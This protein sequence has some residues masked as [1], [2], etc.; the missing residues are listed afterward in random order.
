[1]RFASATVY[2]VGLFRRKPRFD[3]EVQRIIS[4]VTAPG[5]TVTKIDENT[6]QLD[7]L[8]IG[9]A[10]LRAKWDSLDVAERQPWLS[11]ALPALVSPPSI[12]TRLET[13]QPLR[14]G[15]RPRSMLES[16]R[17]NN[18]EHELSAGGSRPLVPFQPFGGDLVTV[19][20]WDAP[21]TMSVVNHAQLE[22]WGA[23]FQDLLPVAI[24]N[25]EDADN[26]GWKATDKRVW[27]SLNQDDYAGARMLVPGF[28]DETGLAGELVVIHPN[29]NLLVV[30]AVDDA[31]GIRIACETA[32]EQLDA[33]SPISFQPL[34]GQGEDWRPLVVPP[35]HPAHKQWQ[36]LN[37]LS[38]E[39]NYKSLQEPLQRL[40]G[41]D[42][43][44]S[45][46][47]IAEAAGGN[48]VS[49]TTWAEGVPS[50]LPR[51]DM[52]GL[53]TERGEAIT[54]DWDSVQLLMGANMEPTDHYPELWRVMS[55]PTSDELAKLR[56]RSSR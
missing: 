15:I 23:R 2:V 19:L 29:R 3:D 14:P 37:C 18:L 21:A 40:V 27:T 16:A 35:S 55:F 5:T 52:I 56:S 8:V 43:F 1:M 42:V 31:D 11:E 26:A 50:L 45:G 10:N 30:T 47:Q 51:A 46:F 48:F 17:L 20:L 36:R 49:V 44:V 34:V 54:A 28:L 13:T 41:Q 53:V 7:G 24:D 9:L 32:L 22:E 33:P 4:D 39:M 12:P 6:L 25:L 38:Q